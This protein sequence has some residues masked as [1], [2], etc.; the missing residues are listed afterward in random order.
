MRHASYTETLTFTHNEIILLDT[1][2]CFEFSNHFVLHFFDFIRGS[3][4][5][6]VFALYVCNVHDIICQNLTLN[7]LMNTK[8]V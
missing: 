8:E 1:N 2:V 4:V 7:L 5:C 3:P 6:S